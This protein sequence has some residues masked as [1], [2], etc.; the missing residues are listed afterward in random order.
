MKPFFDD[1]MNLRATLDRARKS[2]DRGASAIEWVVITAVL[3]I[4]VSVV[5]AIVMSI[6]RERSQT[7]ETC[8]NNA[9]EGNSC[10]GAAVPGGAPDDV[11]APAASVVPAG[12]AGSATDPANLL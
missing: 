10:E 7:L 1:L 9:A 2:D 3:V 4:A 12:A 11:A 8:A 5:G 6:V